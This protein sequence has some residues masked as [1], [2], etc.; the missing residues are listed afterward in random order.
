[1]VALHGGLAAFSQALAGVMELRPE[2]RVLQFA[3]LSFDASAV[4]L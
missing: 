2:D 4:A 1:V 3:S